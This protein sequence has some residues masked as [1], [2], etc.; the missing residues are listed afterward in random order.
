MKTRSL[1][2]M[3]LTLLLALAGCGKLTYSGDAGVDATAPDQM[4][5][6]PRADAAPDGPPCTTSKMAWGLFQWGG[7]PWK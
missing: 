6:L 5:D 3:L 1:K 2:L 7:C 4:T